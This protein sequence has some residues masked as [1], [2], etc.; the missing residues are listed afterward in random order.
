[1][2]KNSLPKREKITTLPPHPPLLLKFLCV[3]KLLVLWKKWVLNSEETYIFIF[4]LIT[5]KADYNLW[6]LRSQIYPL[7]RQSGKIASAKVVSSDLKGSISLFTINTM[8]IFHV[9]YSIDDCFGWLLLP[10]MLLC[11]SRCSIWSDW[12]QR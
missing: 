9:I 2:Y 4:Y 5:F 10:W 6:D 3:V 12:S 8:P 11:T 1:M 7:S